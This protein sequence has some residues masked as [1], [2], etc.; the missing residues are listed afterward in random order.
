M[1]QICQHNRYATS[2]SV[3]EAFFAG[4]DKQAIEI[5]P[6]GPTRALKQ[7]IIDLEAENARLATRVNELISITSLNH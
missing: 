1:S 5:D 7:R 3:C 2:C 6:I 4:F